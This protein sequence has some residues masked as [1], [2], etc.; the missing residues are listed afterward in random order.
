MQQTSY[1]RYGQE[2][3]FAL[4]AGTLAL[5]LGRS[6]EISLT[7]SLPVGV[8]KS[9]RHHEIGQML[10]DDEWH[11]WFDGKK[12][13]FSISPEELLLI[14]EGVGAMSYLM[15]KPSG[16]GFRSDGRKYAETRTVIFDFGGYS[17]DV[18]TMNELQPGRFNESIDMG[19]IDV[20]NRVNAM[21]KD[22]FMRGDLEGA[23]LDE[24]I[25]T[26]QYSHRGD[27]P[28]DVS[29]FVN[30]AVLELMRRAVL[31]WQQS[32]GGGDDVNNVIIA[33]GG[34]PIVGDLLKAQLDH[35]SVTIIED[36]TAH[37]ANVLGAQAYRN[38]RRELGGEG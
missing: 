35:S 11:V 10:T 28:V 24:V 29:S 9:G 25:R 15:L 21:L 12:L 18:L 36:G 5:L 27:L 33:G 23:V 13:T 38:L 14:P 4:I 17:L 31:V 30:E 1:A 8:F 2:E 37:L 16:K 34:G 3:W 7:F 6:A 26:R 19:M 20:R 22:S 32:L